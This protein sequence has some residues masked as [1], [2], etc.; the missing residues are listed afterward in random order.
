MSYMLSWVKIYEMQIIYEMKWQV[1]RF[2]NM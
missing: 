2:Q 1:A